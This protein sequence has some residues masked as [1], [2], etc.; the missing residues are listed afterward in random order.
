V[1][2]LLHNIHLSEA[3]FF[4]GLLLDNQH[5]QGIIAGDAIG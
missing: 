2:L 5:A 1:L 4:S 3:L